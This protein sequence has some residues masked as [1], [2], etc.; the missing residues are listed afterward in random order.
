MA[1]V[2]LGLTIAIGGALAWLALEEFRYLAPYREALAARRGAEL[3]AFVAA[4]AFDLFALLY[5]LSRRLVQG[6]SGR[7]LRRLEREVR[8]GEAFDRELAVRLRDQ[9]EGDA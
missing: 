5:W 4:L 9:R 7:K 1:R 3:A 6:D 2:A 8:R